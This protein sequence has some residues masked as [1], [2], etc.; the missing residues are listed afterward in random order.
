LRALQHLSLRMPS[1]VLLLS[2]FQKLWDAISEWD[3]WLFLKINTEWT[4]G[5]FDS[6][7]P[8]WREANA[9][10]PCTCSSLFLHFSILNK[11]AWAWILFVAVTLTLTDQI[12]SH[13]LKNIF[14]RPRPCRDE[15]LMSQVRLIVNNCSGG[16]SFPFFTCH[17]SLWFCGISFSYTGASDKKMEMDFYCLGSYHLLWTNLCWRSLS[18][19]CIL[20]R[21]IRLL[22]GICDGVAV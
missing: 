6:I 5:F 21:D 11:K 18:C 1:A 8:W 14:E 10:I 19:R 17:Q 12:S 3:T 2:F 20:W 13:L 22:P 16:Y 9:W 7:F 15:F 4:S